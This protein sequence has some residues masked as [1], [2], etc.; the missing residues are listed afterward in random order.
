LEL[1]FTE[2]FPQ[3]KGNDLWL[4]GESY[5]GAYVPQLAQQV[6]LLFYYSVRFG[7]EK[8]RYTEMLLFLQYP[9][10]F[11]SFFIFFPFLGFY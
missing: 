7:E 9:T 2:E 8:R 4:T 6:S 5:A 3:F 1:F 11:Y 10:I